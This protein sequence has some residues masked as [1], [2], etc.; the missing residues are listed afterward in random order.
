MTGCHWCSFDEACHTIGSVYGCSYGETCYNIDSCYRTAPQK[1]SS[2]ENINNSG[3][4]EPSH[5]S[6]TILF[7]I[8]T[9]T[10]IFLLCCSCGMCI[11][12]NVKLAWVDMLDMA[13]DIQRNT[14]LDGQG[15]RSVST[16]GAEA[17]EMKNLLRD[18]KK[19][20]T[21]KSRKVSKQRSKSLDLFDS[22]VR[23]RLIV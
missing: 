22:E 18:G 12:R 6:T 16:P 7:L 23:D 20:E 4:D 19:A 17:F 1:I 15:M 5:V 9:V 13:E 21:R 2:S 11:A 8:V 3:L 14:G 10:L